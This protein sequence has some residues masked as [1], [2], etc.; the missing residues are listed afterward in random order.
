MLA[1]ELL[2][3]CF[4]NEKWALVKNFEQ[5]KKRPAGGAGSNTDPDRI[6]SIIPPGTSSIQ[7]RGFAAAVQFRFIKPFNYF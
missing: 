5:F 1:S 2:C 6:N 7:F 4:V 3:A